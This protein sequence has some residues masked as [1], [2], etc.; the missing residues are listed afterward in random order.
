MGDGFFLSVFSHR[1]AIFR[2]KTKKIT[3][4]CWWFGL[5]CVNLHNN[6]CVVEFIE[7]TVRTKAD[8]DTLQIIMKCRDKLYTNGGPQLAR[9]SSRPEDY[10]GV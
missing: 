7:K 1:G 2:H 9:V 6:K 5:L 8:W 3:D 4:K 10:K